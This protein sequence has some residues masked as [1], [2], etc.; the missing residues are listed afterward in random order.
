MSLD[1]SALGDSLSFVYSPELVS[2]SDVS[3]VLEQALVIFHFLV[4]PYLLKGF[5]LE[6]IVPTVP[7]RWFIDVFLFLK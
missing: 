7:L 1:S 4:R 6:H 3:I 2:L 5:S